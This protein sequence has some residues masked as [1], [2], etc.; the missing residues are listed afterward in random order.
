M[1]F[2]G[3]QMTVNTKNLGAIITGILLLTGCGGSQDKDKNYLADKGNDDDANGQTTPTPTPTPT[4][5]IPACEVALHLIW[6]PINSTTNSPFFISDKITCT[7][8]VHF[9]SF[10]MDKTLTQYLPESIH[11]RP[12]IDSPTSECRFWMTKWT[13]KDR[14]IIPLSS[15]ISVDTYSTM[16]KVN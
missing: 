8:K 11:C 9:M 13:S 15:E 6:I 7:D 5:D 16:A 2:L 12:A 14:A 10:S 4:P 3:E 1:L